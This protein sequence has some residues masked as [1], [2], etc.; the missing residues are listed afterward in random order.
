M[1]SENLYIG[2]MSGTSMDG[3]DAILL[4]LDAGRCQ[5]LATHYA[6]YP[7]EIRNTLLTLIDRR[8]RISLGELGQLDA[9]LG[10]F[11]ADAVMTLLGKTTL[12]P[13]SIKAVGSHGQTVLHHP[14]GALDGQLPYTMQIG[15]PNIIACKTQITTVADF[16][17][18]DIAA[19]GQGAPL[20]PAFHAAFFQNKAEN[21]VVLNIGGIANITVLPADGFVSGFDTGP[22]NTLLDQW[23]KQY[24][25]VEYDSGGNIAGRGKPIAVLLEQLTGD[26]YF[27]MNPPKSTGREYF[28]LAWLEG[29]L[30]N[31]VQYSPT[32]VL[33]TLTALTADTIARAI[34]SHAPETQ[35]VYLCGG[36]I[37]NSTL[38]N[39]LDRLLPEVTLESTAGAGLDPD[40]VEAAAFA[41]LAKQTLEGKPGN[42]PAVT[43]AQRPV[44]LGGIYLK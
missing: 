20:V 10:D 35:R 15:D 7:V 32:D 29:Y 25:D 8:D 31:F 27:Q 43:G 37:H 23:T 19:G 1:I 30:T 4:D 26:R 41:W 40:Y 38:V 9:R 44:V 5:T 42:V 11:Y 21:R 2:L 33:A 39:R 12:A 24:L 3:I 6:P 16:R 22:G 28:N 13:S 14:P 17:R 18:R 34:R 36:G